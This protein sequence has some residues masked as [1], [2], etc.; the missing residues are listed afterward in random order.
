[1]P[2]TVQGARVIA[3]AKGDSAQGGYHLVT[4]KS[5][6]VNKQDH[7]KLVISAGTRIKEG[8][9]IATGSG[10]GCCAVVEMW[11]GELFLRR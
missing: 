3:M 5:Q 4:F 1:M 10:R 8:H 9:G 6:Q 7:F 2:G 11:T